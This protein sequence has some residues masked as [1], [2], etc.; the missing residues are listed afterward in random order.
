MSPD[1]LAPSAQTRTRLRHQVPLRLALPLAVAALMMGVTSTNLW[2]AMQHGVAAVDAR[3]EADVRQLVHR[4]ERRS[5]E[6]DPPDA[7]VLWADMADASTDPRVVALALVDAR[8]VVLQS[9]NRAWVGRAAQDL[10][11]GYT[12]ARLQQALQQMPVD[13]QW[14]DEPRQVSALLSNRWI[15]RGT[16]SPQAPGLVVFAAMQLQTQRDDARWLA[17]RSRLPELLAELLLLVLMAAW[18]QRQVARPLAALKDRSRRLAAGDL[19]ARAELGGADE[20]SQLASA[21]NTMAD[22]QQRAQADL[23]ASEERLATIL[24]STGDALLA[25]DTEQRVTLMNPVAEKLT[26][27]REH[28]ARGRPVQSVFRIEHAHTGAPA[29]IPVERVLKEGHVVG[30]ANHTVLVSRL[31]LRTHIADSA[32]PIRRGDGTLTG[33]VLVF[34]DVNETY[35][36]EQALADSEWHYRA[37]ANAGRALVFT[38]DAQGQNL[39]C[40]DAWMRLTGQTR[41]HAVAGGWV[42]ALHPDDRDILRGQWQ[43]AARSGHSDSQVLRLRRS[44][45]EWRWY[46]VEAVSRRDAAGLHAGLIVQAL[47]VTDQRQAD[48][49]LQAQVDELQRWHHAMLGREARVCELKQEV[50]QVLADKGLPPRYPDAMPDAEPESALPPPAP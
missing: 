24:Y 20:V 21:F 16:L 6:T 17:V 4:L 47:D 42:D 28:E 41:E 38:S 29:A 15:V 2:L 3:G 23:R 44:D 18:L 22:A 49:R 14:Q 12:D 30:L 8:G 48:A 7:S 9:A 33:V 10:L 36:I 35:R 37:L 40:N 45:G 27:W 32:A 13:L 50:N 19:S 46:L 31:G 25:T 26:G 11:P 5:A 34:R 43:R 1:T 39:W